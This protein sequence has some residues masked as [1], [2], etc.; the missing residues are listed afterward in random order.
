MIYNNVFP[1]I[2]AHVALVCV[3]ACYLSSDRL[4]IVNYLTNVYKHAIHQV[5]SCVSVHHVV[6][7]IRTKVELIKV[8]Q[9]V[10]HNYRDLA[11][12]F[13]AEN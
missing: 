10:S 11:E 4:I 6:I 12:R 5:S 13:Q 9:P 7:K 3:S 8:Q 1:L 2:G